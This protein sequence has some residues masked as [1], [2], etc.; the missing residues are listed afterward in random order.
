MLPIILSS[1]ECDSDRELMTTFYSS[2]KDQLYRYTLRF[3]ANHEDAQD[4]F[5][6]MLERLIDH[7]DVF[8]NLSP[9]QRIKYA[10]TTLRN[11]SYSHL[12]KQN[13]MVSVSYDLPDP[14]SDPSISSEKKENARIIHKIWNNLDPEDRAILEQRYI[15]RWTDA[16]IAE[17]L[18]IKPESVRMRLT[19]AR[20]A[21]SKKM[22]SSGFLLSD[23]L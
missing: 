3:L 14:D 1:I 9:L 11:L 5:C 10:Q 8:R 21:L 12:R 19:R 13:N 15:L 23:W 4:I 18:G 7:M 17:P 22:E 20:R 2:Y 6:D 16:Q